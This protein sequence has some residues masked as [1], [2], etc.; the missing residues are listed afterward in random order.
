MKRT[1]IRGII[2]T[3]IICLI[4]IPNVAAAILWG[5]YITDTDTNS[6]TINWKTEDAT[7]GTVKYAT[8]EYYTEHGD[9]DH[10]IVDKKKQLHSVTIT[11]LKSDMV[12]HYQVKIKNKLTDDHIF[13]TLLVNGSFTF[14]VY[15]DTREQTGLFTQMERHKLVADRIAEEKNIS[16]VIHTGDLVSSGSDLNEWN[17]FFNAGQAMLA[18]TTIYP[19]LGNHEDNHTNYYDAFKLPAWHSFDCGNAHFTMLDSND[20]ADTASQTAWLQDGLDCDANWKFV[21]FH[22]PIYSSDERHFGGWKN[23][24]WEDIFINNSVDAVFNGHVHVY[25]R[26]EKSGIQYMVV[27][28]GGAPLYSLSMEKIPGYQNSLEHT[29]G[30]VKITISGEETIIDVIKV[31]DISEDNV[32]VTYIYPPNTVFETIMFTKGQA[33]DST[34]LTTTASVNIPM[35]GISLNRTEIDYG[36]IRAGQNLD[37]EPIKITNI[38]SSDVDVT[39]EVTGAT[40]VAQ[41]FYEQ[42]LHVDE[43]LYNPV[44]VIV[45][46]PTANT[47]DVV[48]QLRVPYSWTDAG[49]QSAT[50]VFWA[51][52]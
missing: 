34:S 29:L 18:N 38:G 26:Y 9:Y 17:D 40:M 30:Y 44:M 24:A 8:D 28:C 20:W 25:E 41:S 14:I 1:K 42:S 16:F 12:Y 49:T 2:G 32:N 36:N 22:H 3:V 39:L 23:D 13:K 31:A 47:E 35:V 48:T 7:L 11:D 5:P 51:E 46:I 10:T 15:G 52:V 21:S 27:G 33:A 4:L 43:S 50:F 45:Q 19:V 6:T 37:N